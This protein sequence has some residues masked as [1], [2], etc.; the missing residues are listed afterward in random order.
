MKASTKLQKEVVRLDA[1]RYKI[2]DARKL[3]LFNKY[4]PHRGVQWKHGSIRCTSCGH[5]WDG[6]PLPK[7]T[8]LQYITNDW[9]RTYAADFL[10]AKPH[11]KCT[12][13]NCNRKLDLVYAR[14]QIANRSW[15]FAKLMVVGSFQVY[16][17]MELTVYWRGDY[18][19]R[20]GSDFR[21]G[22]ASW[23]L[24]ETGSLWMRPGDR[25]QYI[26][27]IL[28]NGYYGTRWS[29]GWDL[30][31]QTRPF[32]NLIG[33]EHWI[34]KPKLLPLIEKMGIDWTLE[35]GWIK[36]M[37]G[38]MTPMGET[39]WKADQ[40]HLF[41]Y[42]LEDTQNGSRDH[43]KWLEKNWVLVKHAIRKGLVIKDVRS[44]VDYQMQVE[45]R[46]KN[47][48]SP[49]IMANRNWK[50]KHQEYNL[51]EA[52]RR[53]R[54]RTALEHRRNMEQ[55]KKGRSSLKKKMKIYGDV[56][57]KVGHIEIVPMKT[58]EQM[59]DESALL[60]HCAYSSNYHRK[61]DSL[62]LSARY[63][64]KI[65]ETI[66]FDLRSMKPVQIRG[67]RNKPSTFNDDVREIMFG[68]GADIIDAARRKYNRE[69]R[70]KK[71]K[72]QSQKAS[73]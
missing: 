51:I 64:D 39:L 11:G 10:E 20:D 16:V 26:G 13:P 72:V 42:L 63:D 3:Q 46:G 24:K 33:Y 47:P 9:G 19:S 12:C 18:R 54:A 58:V 5:R 44:W 17:E 1:R 22:K 40:L 4:V 6:D 35:E 48:L 66:E 32:K 69:Q 45:Q 56:H 68:I 7:N 70:A 14:A 43:R 23:T 2:S 49:E 8:R 25:P 61:K 62:M 34:Q 73:A 59:R 36:Q 50:K 37:A 21:P 31:D 28:G 41:W 67:Y 38:M 60:Q 65:V 29:F 30:R 27:Y 71:K 15:H 55:L 53:E 52:R 57:I